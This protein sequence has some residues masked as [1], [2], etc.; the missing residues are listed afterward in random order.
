MP[1]RA[2]KSSHAARK[3][4]VWGFDAGRRMLERRR[5]MAGRRKRGSWWAKRERRAVPVRAEE[6]RREGMGWDIRSGRAGKRRRGRLMRR[7]W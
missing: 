6:R 3:M 4:L 7:C 1:S 2:L 5:G